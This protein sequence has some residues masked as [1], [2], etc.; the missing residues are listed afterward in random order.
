MQIPQH[1]KCD[2]LAALLQ[3]LQVMPPD[4]GMAVGAGCCCGPSSGG[5][6]CCCC[7]GNMGT[8]DFKQIAAT[9]TTDVGSNSN[10]GGSAGMA[11][12]KDPCFCKT[13]PPLELAP[14]TEA[15]EQHCMLPEAMHDCGREVNLGIGMLVFGG[16][17]TGVV[18][19]SS[20]WSL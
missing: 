13:Q 18:A 14:P 3:L 17:R 4:V 1:V 8:L 11:G 20:G 10:V 16:G 5:A 2:K 7:C 9:G 19:T 6:G 15:R 12:R